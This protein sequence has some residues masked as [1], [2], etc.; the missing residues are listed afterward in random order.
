MLTLKINK[1]QVLP[2][3]YNKMIDTI[4][5][6][7]VS[8]IQI[9]QIPYNNSHDI[10]VLIQWSPYGPNPA[11][12][13]ANIDAEYDDDVIRCHTE[14]MILGITTYMKSKY[15]D[16]GKHNWSVYFE[17]QRGVFCESDET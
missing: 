12:M 5:K 15:A 4:S 2:Y 10:E 6:S 3:E 9:E 1:D 14:K 8:S 11:I 17:L 16:Y 13:V 7:I